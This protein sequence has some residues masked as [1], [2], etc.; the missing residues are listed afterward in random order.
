MNPTVGFAVEDWNL[1][2]KT[3]EFVENPFNA[4][5]PVTLT[6]NILSLFLL[7]KKKKI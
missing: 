5:N 7:E 4:L 6:L 1:F 2:A 3:E